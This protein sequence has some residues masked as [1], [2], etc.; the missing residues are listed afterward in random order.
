MKICR[1]KLKNIHSLKGEHTVDFVNGVLADAGLFLITGSTGAG[2][3]TLLDVITLALYNRIPRIDKAITRTVVEEEGV[4]LTKH[5]KDCFA[6]VEFLVNGVQYRANWS[7]SWNRAGNLNERLH[8]I[9][10]VTENN[11]IL[12]NRISEVP[13]EIEKIIGLN[14]EQFVQSMILAQGQFA[15]LLLAKKDERTKLLEDITGTSIYRSIG[16]KV[17]ERYTLANRKEGEHRLIMGENILL[18]SSELL[19]INQELEKIEPILI[20]NNA[21]NEQLAIK[22]EL[23]N[24]I[25][26]LLLRQTE[27][28]TISSNLEQKRTQLAPEIAK[29]DTHNNFVV[30][31]NEYDLIIQNQ[32]KEAVLSNSIVDLLSST[33]ALQQQ[34]DAILVEASGL[35]NNEVSSAN[36]ENELNAFQTKVLGFL[37]TEKQIENTRKTQSSIFDV[38]QNQLLA[39]GYELQVSEDIT[40]QLQQFLNDI[41]NK[42]LLL[43]V[44]SHAELITEK[45]RNTNLKIPANNLIA[46]RRIADITLETITNREE[47]IRLHDKAK[48]DSSNDLVEIINQEVDRSR[49]FEQ[50]KSQL[51]ESRK[52]KDFDGLRAELKENCP[53]SLCGS[54]LHPYVIEHKEVLLDAQQKTF[55]GLEQQLNSLKEQKNKLVATI[56]SLTNNVEEE[57]KVLKTEKEK[58]QLNLNKIDQLVEV[59]NWDI[60]QP[61]AEWSEKLKEIE[62]YHE[63]LNDLEKAFQAQ[64]MIKE[65]EVVHGELLKLKETFNEVKAARQ[66]LYSGNDIITDIANKK[67]SFTTAKLKLEADLSLLRNSEIEKTALSML[68]KQTISELSKKLT[69]IGIANWMDLSELILSELDANNLRNMLQEFKDEEVALKTNED[70]LAEELAL[71]THNDDKAVSLAE[72]TAEMAT[73]TEIIEQQTRKKWELEN[74]INLDKANR[75][76]QQAN[77]V[78]LD[79]LQRDL[80]LWTKMNL[81]IGDSSGKKFSHFV[82]ELTL[83]QLISYGN[84]RL[85]SFS[86]R[87]LLDSEADSDYLMVLDTYMGNSHRSVSSLSG[88]ETFKLSLALAFGL[89]DLAAKNVNIESLFIDEGFGTLDPE[90]LDQAITILENMQNTSN[91]SIGIISHVGELKDRIGTKIKLVKSGSGYSTIQIE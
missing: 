75:E 8:E 27:L 71:A 44:A 41:E 57:N 52:I 35:V 32:E 16:K 46:E 91:K 22:K 89:S 73:I 48:E 79:G 38:H 76:K 33:Q 85:Q 23:K 4:I 65:I 63:Q 88:G 72:V 60:N 13:K 36:F 64:S 19:A 42:S 83:K 49:E 3:S 55:N 10:N 62:V 70:T 40:V 66:A 31:R 7:M 26:K 11:F 17:Y 51:E 69:P 1:I 77:Q 82:Q 21:K 12:S 90:S 29:L 9:V 80:N 54:T 78:I 67:K 45:E 30:F 24:N 39:L 58:Y 87:Y 34:V 53:C 47:R 15:K 68:L 74:K 50:A 86:D 2:K 59:L 20:D 43:K 37:D 14:Y 56:D 18:Q 6:E 81:L 61:V 28:K 84:E 5:A 25:E